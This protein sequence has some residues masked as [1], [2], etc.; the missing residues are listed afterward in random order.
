MSDS[1]YHHPTAEKAKVKWRGEI[2]YC[3]LCSPWKSYYL[4]RNYVYR[5]KRDEGII[6]AM[7][8]A[9]FQRYCTI[10][11]SKSGRMNLP[12]MRRGFIDGIMGKL[13]RTVEPGQVR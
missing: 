13:G 7:K 5:L 2:I 8:E 9:Y 1:I 12:L 4:M 11:A 6:R 3:E 10:R